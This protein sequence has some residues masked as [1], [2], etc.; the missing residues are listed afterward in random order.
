MIVVKKIINLATVFNNISLP[1]CEYYSFKSNYITHL[2]SVVNINEYGNVITHCL[3]DNSFCKNINFY[4]NNDTVKCTDVDII[5]NRDDYYYHYDTIYNLCNSGDV[6]Y[7]KLYYMYFNDTIKC[8]S[9]KPSIYYMYNNNTNLW[10]IA[11]DYEI[12]SHFANNE[13]IIKELLYSRTY[14]LLCFNGD[15][16]NSEYVEKYECLKKTTTTLKK[17][18]KIKSLLC[19]IKSVFYDKSFASKLNNYPYFLPVKNGYLDSRDGSL[20]EKLEN[21]FF[22]FELDVEW[23]GINFDTSYF[24]NFFYNIM[25]KNKQFVDFLQKL[26]GYCITGIVSEQ[27]IIIFS[28]NCNVK[29][30]L[31]K[32]LSNLMSLYSK[33][34]PIDFFKYKSNKFSSD[35]KLLIHL[36]GNR[37]AF[38]D[39]FDT[40]KP[41]N[42]DFVKYLCE[43]TVKID[44]KN[45]NKTLSFSPSHHLFI[46]INDT[47]NLCDYLKQHSIIIPLSIEFDNIDDINILHNKLDQLLVWL[48][49]GSVNYI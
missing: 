16:K 9:K 14:Y 13:I 11:S 28:G 46:Y 38:I 1:K 15:F 21:V 44:T 39:S 3:F 18:S 8:I 40:L 42:I 30:I 12:I 4:I 5:R 45:N 33:T 7:V 22:S 49:K 20:C 34:L 27:K 41:I 35:N 29:N 43:N 19:G 23:K 26:L 25:R 24:D 37:I 36:F 2:K 47:T 32:L 31:F 10:Q 6:G 17:T 48:V